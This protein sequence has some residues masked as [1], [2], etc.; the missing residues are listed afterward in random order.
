MALPLEPVPNAQLG[1][2]LQH[3][4]IGAKKDVQTGFVPVAVFVLPGRHLAAE[5][6]AG[7]VNHRGMAGIAQVFGTGQPR[8]PRT[9]NRHPHRCAHHIGAL[10]IELEPCPLTTAGV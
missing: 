2:Q 9:R 1:K 5:H 3:V 4:G 8:Q 6:I 10:T 7:F